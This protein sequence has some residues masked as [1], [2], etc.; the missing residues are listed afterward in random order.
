MTGQ[1]T[2]E[3]ALQW[4]RS[5]VRKLREEPSSISDLIIRGRKHALPLRDDHGNWEKP[6]TKKEIGTRGLPKLADVARDLRNSS[7]MLD[8]VLS[9]KASA[10]DRTAEMLKQTLYQE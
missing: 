8:F 1:K 7:D 5:V 4:H 3:T 2:W 10:N 6:L 9:M